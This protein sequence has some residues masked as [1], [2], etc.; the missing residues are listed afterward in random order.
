MQFTVK[1]T[2]GLERRIEV[3][4]PQTRVAGEVDRKLRDLSRTANVKGFRKGK[5]PLPVIKQQY[6]SQVHGDTVS[7]LIRQ[8]YS[9]AVT[10][11][12]TAAG[13][14]SAFRAHPGCAGMR[15]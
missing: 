10:K 7:E 1:T 4:I 14:R 9:E 6:G 3:E 8:T 13:W 2:A 15:T 11:G 12:E 5:V